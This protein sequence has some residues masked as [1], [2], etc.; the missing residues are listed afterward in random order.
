[1]HQRALEKKS[2]IQ[3]KGTKHAGSLIKLGGTAEVQ[4]ED[5]FGFSPAGAI[6]GDAG[7][8]KAKGARKEQEPKGYSRGAKG[9]RAWSMEANSV[10]PEI[11]TAKHRGKS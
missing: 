6:R 5:Y 3:E 10:T 7:A 9:G 2:T 11:S 1:M 8:G 4:G